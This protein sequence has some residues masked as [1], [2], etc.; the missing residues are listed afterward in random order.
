MDAIKQV[1]SPTLLSPAYGRSYNNQHDMLKDWHDGLDFRVYPGGPY[2]SIRDL[3]YLIDT[4]STVTL[5]DNRTG[6][7]VLVAGHC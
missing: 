2:T 1:S 3:Q 4:S 6:I 7:S 5:Y